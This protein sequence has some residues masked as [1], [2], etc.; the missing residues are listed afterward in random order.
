MSPEEELAVL[1]R[2]DAAGL[3]AERVYGFIVQASEE[4]GIEYVRCMLKVR[5]ALEEGFDA[6]KRAITQPSQRR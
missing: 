3:E 2:I 5:A 4:D 6:A 1:E